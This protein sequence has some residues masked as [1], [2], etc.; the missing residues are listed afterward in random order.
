MRNLAQPPRFVREAQKEESPARAH[1]AGVGQVSQAGFLNL[2]GHAAPTGLRHCRVSFPTWKVPNK[3]HFLW[4]TLP[5]T[6]SSWVYAPR[7]GPER[8]SPRTAPQG[9]HLTHREQTRPYISH[10]QV[11]GESTRRGLE[12]K[13]RENHNVHTLSPVSFFPEASPVLPTCS[14]QPL[15]LP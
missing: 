3:A 14:S 10:P 9:L 15:S 4:G 7:S 13:Q 2:G 12:Q 6:H 1:K 5:S 8:A 11:T